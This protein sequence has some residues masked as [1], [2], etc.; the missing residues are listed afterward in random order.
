MNSKAEVNW[1]S[2]HQTVS[3]WTQVY[4]TLAATMRENIEKKHGVN[5]MQN[6][7]EG[8]LHTP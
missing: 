2:L 5:R 1:C 8:L 7:A 6:E 4:K 3:A